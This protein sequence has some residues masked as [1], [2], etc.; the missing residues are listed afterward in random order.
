MEL[1]QSLLMEEKNDLVSK[2]CKGSI[3]REHFRE[4]SD[5]FYNAESYTV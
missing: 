1:F 3:G 2:V 5:D 4:I